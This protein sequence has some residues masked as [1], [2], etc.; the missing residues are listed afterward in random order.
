MNCFMLAEINAATILKRKQDGQWNATTARQVTLEHVK[1]TWHVLTRMK[2]LRLSVY[3]V[4]WF[5]IQRQKC[6]FHL[7]NYIVWHPIRGAEEKHDAIG[8]SRTNAMLSAIMS[9]NAPINSNHTTSSFSPPY[10]VDHVSHIGAWH[11]LLQAS[12]EATTV[13]S[14]LKRLISAGILERIIASSI[15]CMVRIPK[16]PSV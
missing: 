3:L 8:D 7:E 10:F 1:D 12:T 14:T 2:R 4:R 13:G 5:Q 15:K 16:Y 6:T 11:F 9:I